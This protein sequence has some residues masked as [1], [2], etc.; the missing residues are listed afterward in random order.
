[1]KPECRGG[2]EAK[3]NFEKAMKSR[4]RAPKIPSKNDGSLGTSR[5]IVLASKGLGFVIPRSLRRARPVPISEGFS[6]K[7]DRS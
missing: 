2:P 7:P 6:P 4:F 5:P 3:K 1:M